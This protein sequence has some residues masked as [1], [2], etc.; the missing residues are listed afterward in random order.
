MGICVCQQLGDMKFHTQGISLQLLFYLSILSFN[1]HRR[2]TPS[3]S[4][5]LPLSATQRCC[6]STASSKSEC[7]QRFTISHSIIL[8]KKNLFA[9]LVS[10]HLKSHMVVVY[11]FL[12]RNPAAARGRRCKT[13]PI[14]PSSWCSSC[15]CCQR[16]SATSPFTVR[17]RLA[18]LFYLSLTSEI[19]ALCWVSPR[20]PF[21]SSSCTGNVEAELLHTFTK[22]Y[23]FDTMLLLVRL[24]VLTAVTL[25]VPIVLFPVSSSYFV[26]HFPLFCFFILFLLLVPGRERAWG[27]PG[28]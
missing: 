23:K 9:N 22:V 5:L 26:A 12:L 17:W 7:L 2:P 6:P 10:A 16:S 15:T 24:A 13:C 27:S 18:L 4:W 8:G 28:C 1:F 3:P 19:A 25:T 14:C 11:V 21:N 20:L